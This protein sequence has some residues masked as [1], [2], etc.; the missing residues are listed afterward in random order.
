MCLYI[1][2]FLLNLVLMSPDVL[3]KSLASVACKWHFVHFHKLN[4]ATYTVQ[5]RIMLTVMSW[6]DLELL[7]SSYWVPVISLKCIMNLFNG[8]SM[9]CLH[10]LRRRSVLIHWTRFHTEKANRYMDYESRTCEVR[11]SFVLCTLGNFS[12]DLTRSLSL[13][14]VY[15]SSCGVERAIWAILARLEPPMPCCGGFWGWGCVCAGGDRTTCGGHGVPGTGWIAGLLCF[16]LK[17]FRLGGGGRGGGTK[18]ASL[19]RRGSCCI[20]TL[21]AAIPGDMSLPCWSTVNA[22]TVWARGRCPLKTDS[23]LWDIPEDTGRSP[24]N[25]NE[26]LHKSSEMNEETEWTR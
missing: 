7:F 15:S 3:L 22:P 6:S 12:R 4:F 25:H 14:S 20:T 13:L 5:V 23:R 8:H 24:L 2:L 1:L 11:L 17:R 18:L 26:I 19:N 9:N 21:Q 10:N 16:M